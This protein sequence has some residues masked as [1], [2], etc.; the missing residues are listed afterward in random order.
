MNAT[1]N[2]EQLRTCIRHLKDGRTVLVNIRADRRSYEVARSW[3]V[4]FMSLLIEAGWQAPP[5]IEALYRELSDYG[6]SSDDMDD[7]IPF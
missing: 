5:E 1:R 7:G 2:K 3:L 4:A 6:N